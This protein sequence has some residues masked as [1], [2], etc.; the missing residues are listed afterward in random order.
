[1]IDYKGIVTFESFPSMVV[2]E[3]LS[4]ALAIWRNLCED[5]VDLETHA[6]ASTAGG[7]NAAA[8]AKGAPL[9]KVFY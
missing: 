2:N 9:T 4:N 7:I 5:S 3:Q 8:N 6:R 1:M